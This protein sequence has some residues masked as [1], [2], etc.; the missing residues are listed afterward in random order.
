M[1]LDRDDDFEES[2]SD[3]GSL[4]GAP[5]NGALWSFARYVTTEGERQQRNNTTS[6][7]VISIPKCQT[8]VVLIDSI[9]RNP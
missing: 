8:V 4:A 7:K 2:P 1:G 3:N 5:A 9:G 6:K